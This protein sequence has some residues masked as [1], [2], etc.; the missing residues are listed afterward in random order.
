M[1]NV[2][3]HLTDTSAWFLNPKFSKMVVS[4]ELE[5]QA[6]EIFNK[7]HIKMSGMEKAIEE[8][9]EIMKGE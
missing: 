3:E 7:D 2:W 9:T 8:A 5:K 6:F 1:K 4:P